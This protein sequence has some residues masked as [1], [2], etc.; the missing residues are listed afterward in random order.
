MLIN[1]P[2]TVVAGLSGGSGKTLV[3]AG[4]TAALR[5]RGFSIQTF[6]KGPDFID[7]AWLARASG[8]PC[9]NLDTYMMG[10]YRV[11]RSFA[12]RAAAAQA[13]VIEGNRGIFDGVDAE[14][15]H[16]TARLAQTLRAPIVLTVDCTKSTRT[17]AALIL[18]CVNFEDVMGGKGPGI[19]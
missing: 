12:I 2:R 10:E 5:A 18:G 6:K 14:G 13:S 15:S 3:S 1:N 4:V 17:I 19:A 16:S 8:R 9:Y 11:V 7:A